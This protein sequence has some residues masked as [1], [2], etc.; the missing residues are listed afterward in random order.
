MFTMRLSNQTAHCR[1]AVALSGAG[2]PQ[3][4]RKARPKTA[5]D[6]WRFLVDGQTSTL[7][8]TTGVAR[9][10]KGSRDSKPDSPF[11]ILGCPI[12]YD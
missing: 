6:L 5:G 8:W 2:T 9:L 3:P 10:P 12:T 11:S 1:D 7:D 4:T